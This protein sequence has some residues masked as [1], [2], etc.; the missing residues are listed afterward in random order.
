[1]IIAMIEDH[2]RVCGESQGY[3]PLPIRDEKV[4]TEHGTVPVMVTAWT[5][6]P[7]ELQ[8]LNNGAS[9]HVRILGSMPP[10]M[11][12]GVGPLPKG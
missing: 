5:P 11:L 2:T 4:A 12:V 10:P 9:V 1:M 3:Q 8:A 6:T 7:A